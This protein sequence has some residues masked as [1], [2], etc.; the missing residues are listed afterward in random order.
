MTSHFKKIRELYHFQVFIVFTLL[1]HLGP[2]VFHSLH[3]TDVIPSN[4]KAPLHPFDHRWI[5]FLSNLGHQVNSR[6]GITWAFWVSTR[7]APTS[8]KWSYNPY[9]WPYNWVTGVITLLME[10]ITP[11]ITSRGPTFHKAAVF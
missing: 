3:M 4:T 1:L 5:I 11:L 2:G 9:K 7:W 8:Y 10:V 6:C